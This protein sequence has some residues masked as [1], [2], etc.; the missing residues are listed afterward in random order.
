M[1][2]FADLAGRKGWDEMMYY[3]EEFMSDEAIELLDYA[4]REGRAVYAD[5]LEVDE[6]DDEE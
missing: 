6:D 1:A 3:C 5:W 2:L 4:V